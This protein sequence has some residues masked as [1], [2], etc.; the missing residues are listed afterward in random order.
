LIDSGAPEVQCQLRSGY[1][2]PEIKEA[3]ETEVYSL[4]LMGTAGKSLVGE[5][6]LGGVANDV[7]KFAP[8]PV[9]LIPRET[10]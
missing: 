5:K 6:L 4:V 7:V 1:P 8:C 3:L 10:L 2:T 9:L